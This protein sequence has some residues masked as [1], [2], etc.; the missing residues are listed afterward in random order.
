MT[1]ESLDTKLMDPHI[2]TQVVDSREVEAEA[3]LR[4]FPQ[5]GVPEGTDERKIN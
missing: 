3:W 2:D 5:G 4:D 1:C